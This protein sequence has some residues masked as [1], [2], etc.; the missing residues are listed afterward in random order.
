MGIFDKKRFS[1]RDVNQYEQYAMEAA[2]GAMLAE[3][4][5]SR[6]VAAFYRDPKNKGV[7]PYISKS[8]G[9]REFVKQQKQADERLKRATA[10]LGHIFLGMLQV[11]ANG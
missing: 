5:V 8:K 4:E 6:V 10:P 1:I 11:K 7:N 9:A 2:V 3:E